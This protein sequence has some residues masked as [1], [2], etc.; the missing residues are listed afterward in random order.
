M[1]TVSELATLAYNM[2]ACKPAMLYLAN[3]EPSAPVELAFDKLTCSNRDWLFWIIDRSIY[4]GHVASMRD[5]LLAVHDIVFRFE[6]VSSE[7][8][9]KIRATFIDRLDACMTDNEYWALYDDEFKPEF[10]RHQ[11]ALWSAEFVP[12]I[13]PIVVRWLH[14]L[15]VHS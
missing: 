11:Y 7:L 8:F 3:L 10:F 13:R 6:R 15:E 12:Q 4:S 2:R 9:E 14:A 5:E 1:K